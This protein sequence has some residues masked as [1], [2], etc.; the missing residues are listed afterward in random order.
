M[1]FMFGLSF[2]AT[3]LALRGFEPLLIALLRFALAGGILWL[4]WRRRPQRE[5]LTRADLR[6]LALIGFVRWMVVVDDD[7]EDESEDDEAVEAARS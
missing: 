2:V 6:R 5:P 3:K 1:T 4:L 7:P